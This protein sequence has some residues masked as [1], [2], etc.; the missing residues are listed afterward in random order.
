MQ[1]Y[2]PKSVRK[3]L[4]AL[5]S[6]AGKNLASVS[7][8]HSFTET[9]LHLSVTLFGLISPLHLSNLRFKLY[10][11]A[12]FIVPTDKYYITVSSGCQCFF[13]SHGKI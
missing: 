7:V 3:L 8:R 1:V 13:D 11:T 2:K 5:R 6:A 12:T 9:V 4:S 10:N